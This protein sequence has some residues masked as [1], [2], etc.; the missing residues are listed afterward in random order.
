[1]QPI[2]SVRVGKTD[3]N[4]SRLGLGAAPLGSSEVYE[5]DAK[6][7][8]RAALGAG[9]SFIDTAPLYGAGVSEERLGRALTDAP[10]DSFVLATKVGRTV[11][12]ERKVS[13]D[14][15]RDAVLRSI[16]ASLL[17]LRTDRIDILHLHDPDA[18][19]REA[20]DV[21]FPVL[22]DLR[23]QAA[24]VPVK[25][26]RYGEWGEQRRGNRRP[27]VATRP[28]DSFAQGLEI[29]K[30]IA[31]G[32][33]NTEIAPHLVLSPKTVRN[34]VANILSK[35]QVAIAR[36]PVFGHATPGWNRWCHG[37]E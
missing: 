12:E 31:Q 24:C 17:R 35:L 29:L 14:W 6:A 32:H 34:Y 15:T 3:L 7:T 8:V 27:S 11:S 1:M 33:N 28:M 10:R 23:S 5:S 30:L 21:V 20:L 36:R 25:R 37:L 22:A 19:Y 13:F 9:V 2:F 16:E 4:V 18:H 26:T